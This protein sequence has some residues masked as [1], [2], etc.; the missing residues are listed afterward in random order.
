MINFLPVQY[1]ELSKARLKYLADLADP[2]DGMWE[3]AFFTHGKHWSIQLGDDV[4]G[5]CGA[6]AEHALLGFQIFGRRATEDYFQACL[7][8]LGFKTAFVSTAEPTYLSLC[9]SN[10]AS[11]EINALMYEDDGT[12]PSPGRFADHTEY[13]LV[14]MS[15]FEKAISFGL[16]AI[17]PQREWLE[18]YYAERIE[19]EELFGVWRN[20]RLIGAGELRISPSQPG[21]ADVG[22]VVAPNARKQGLA[23]EILRQLRYDGRHR[24]YR[25][26]CSTETDNFAAQKA[27][28]KAGFFSK[29][30][31]LD[32]K[33]A[34][35]A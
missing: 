24:G 23:T 10:H 34:A 8:E 35:T 16:E 7:R 26:V 21:I 20:D 9:L 4:I 13:R 33:L 18:G 6:N 17:G 1:S 25:V 3:D 15:D 27:I 5:Y 28:V 12:D 31:I 14:S 30:R 29:H 19:T 32:V 2:L 11:I 22:M